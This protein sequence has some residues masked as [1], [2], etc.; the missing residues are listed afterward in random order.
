MLIAKKDVFDKLQ[1]YLNH[2]ITLE[3]LVDWAEITLMK[4]E[5][6]EADFDV[7]RDVIC[8]LGVADVKAFRLTWEECESFINQLGYKVKFDFEYA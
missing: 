4:Y 2:I 6:A 7:I 1:Q 3:D 5:F 8:R